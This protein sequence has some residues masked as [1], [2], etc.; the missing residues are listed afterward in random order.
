MPVG[1][2]LFLKELG[3][4][5]ND[6]CTQVTICEKLRSIEHIEVSWDKKRDSMN[7]KPGVIGESVHDAK[8]WEF[9]EAAFD[10]RWP[11]FNCYTRSQQLCKDCNHVARP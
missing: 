11:S 3:N 6:Q 7:W 1:C 2:V 5:F 9:V 10:S 4:M 8:K